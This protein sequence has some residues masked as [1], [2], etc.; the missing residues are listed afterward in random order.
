MD[1][2]PLIGYFANAAQT[3]PEF[4]PPHD[5]PCLIC[6]KPL[7]PDDV[8]TISVMDAEGAQR[9]Y[10]YR[11]HRTCHETLSAE[12]RGDLDYRVLTAFQS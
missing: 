6:E 8:R 5:A 3:I 9:S 11:V 12:Q 4:D 2:L 7:S 10:F 1:L